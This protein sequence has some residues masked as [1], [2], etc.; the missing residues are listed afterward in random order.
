MADYKVLGTDHNAF[1]V[2]DMDR[3]IELFCKVL[4]FALVSD[5]EADSSLVKSLTGIDAPLRYVYLQGPDG[6]QVELLQYHGPSDRE[7][8][9]LPARP[10]SSARSGHRGGRRP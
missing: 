4:G 1:T 8:A 2:S 10:P 9:R 7:T 5:D 3:S 6:H